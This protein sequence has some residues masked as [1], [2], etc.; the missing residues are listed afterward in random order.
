[1]LP[2]GLKLEYIDL[3]VIDL[4]VALNRVPG[5][6]TATTCHGHWKY[7]P[8]TLPSKSGWVYFFTER[9]NP[10]HYD[11]VERVKN[12]CENQED[13]S[14]EPIDLEGSRKLWQISTCFELENLP[15]QKDPFSNWDSNQ[16]RNYYK[17]AKRRWLRHLRG[18]GD[19]SQIV[20]TFLK[21]KVSENPEKLKYR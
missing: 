4:V 1:M 15:P 6:N 19:L 10:L 7:A 11:L 14:V 5:I 9:E 3:G 20:T 21:E 8:P 18:F 13:F 16:R 2:K 12:F 17:R